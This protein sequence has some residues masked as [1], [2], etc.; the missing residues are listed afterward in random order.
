MRSASPG[1]DARRNFAIPGGLGSAS[2][3]SA[4]EVRSMWGRFW[5]RYRSA[6]FAWCLL[7][8]SHAVIARD[9][10]GLLDAR[11]ILSDIAQVESP[12]GKSSLSPARV[13]VED[14]RKY[15]TTASTL[16]AEVAANTWIE[17]YDR[18]VKLTA[19]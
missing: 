4:R 17:L 7:G 8:A 9:E 12:Q 5:T 16:T 15:R 6:A 10:S 1:H 19:V 14:I 18:T 3:S 13:L 2:Q 11:A